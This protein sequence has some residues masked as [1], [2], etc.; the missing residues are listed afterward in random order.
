MVLVV[1]GVAILNLA[2]RALTVRQLLGVLHPMR[3]LGPALGLCHRLIGLLPTGLPTAGTATDDLRQLRLLER[4]ARWVSRDPAT[5]GEVMAGIWELLN[6]ILLLDANALLVTGVE[7]RRKSAVLDRVVDWMGMVDMARS[8]ASL[9]AEPRGWSIPEWQ[10]GAVATRIDGAWHPLLADP[11]PNDI[12]LAVGGGMLITGANMAGK[13]TYLRTVALATLLSDC[14]GTAPARSFRGRR[15]R[16]MS[17]IGVRDDLSAG[18]S[19]F[20]VESERVAAML[21]VAREGEGHLFILDELFRGTNTIERM[22]LT[23][24]VMHGLVESHAPPCHVAVVAT[25]DVEVASAVVPP[26]QA[27]HFRETF[28]DGKLSFD[29]LRREVRRPP[30]PGSGCSRPPARHPR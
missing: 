18:K 10:D 9:R 22:A 3:Q 15:L 26:Y 7:L 4:V 11:T 30:A 2:I 21:A 29:H 12:E 13:S 27:W 23:E 8:V 20:Q 6:Q 25:H 1:A 17:L 24:A 14:L 5:D 28:E 19:H 16:V